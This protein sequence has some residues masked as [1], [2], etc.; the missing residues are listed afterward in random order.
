MEAIAKRKVAVIDV[1]SL[2]EILE[3]DNA[4]LERHKNGKSKVIIRQ[5]EYLKYEHCAE[6]YEHLQK[7]KL[8]MEIENRELTPLE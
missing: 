7:Y 2:L 8:P 1:L 5:D 4:S 3:M 6:L